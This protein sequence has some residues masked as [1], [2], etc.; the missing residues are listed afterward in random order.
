MLRGLKTQ[1]SFRVTLLADADAL[2]AGSLG[3]LIGLLVYLPGLGP[4]FL[5]PCS[6]I[7]TYF[8]V[9]RGFALAAFHGCPIW[10][11]IL[12]TLLHALLM[13]C[14]TLGFLMM[15]LLLFAQVLG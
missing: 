3:A 8:W 15:L 6:A 13:G 11:G 12:A 1:H 10:K 9:L 2:G 14:C 5:V 4:L 7:A